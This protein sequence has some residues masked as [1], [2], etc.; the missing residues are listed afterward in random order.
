MDKKNVIIEQYLSK[1]K[2]QI[3][4]LSPVDEFIDALRQDLYEYEETNPN[5]TEE[6]LE[7]EFGTPEEIASDFLR[8]HPTLQPKAVAKSKRIR[9]IIIAI[10]VVA[11]I[12]GGFIFADFL[13]HRQ[14]KATDVII[15]EE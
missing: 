5:F 12:A 11:L 7:L 2:A 13:S 1:I 6:D 9:N 10:L 3:Y 14:V 4:K 15:I 8:E